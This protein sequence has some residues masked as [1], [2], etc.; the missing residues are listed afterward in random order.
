MNMA[1]LLTLLGLILVIEGIPWFLSPPLIKR[2]IRKI[3]MASDAALRL[4]GLTL[5]LTGLL[6]VYLAQG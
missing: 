2:T 3:A 1:F 6:L 4:L 5:M